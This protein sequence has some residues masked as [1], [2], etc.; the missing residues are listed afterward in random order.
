MGPLR[1]FNQ[2]VKDDEQAGRFFKWVFVSFVALIFLLFG[3]IPQL[4]LF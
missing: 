3:I 4:R 1:R 2:W